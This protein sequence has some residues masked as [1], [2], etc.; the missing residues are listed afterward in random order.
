MQ[1]RGPN[2]PHFAASAISTKSVAEK[3]TSGTSL[4]SRLRNINIKVLAWTIGVLALLSMIATSMLLISNYIA[5]SELR[6][7]L[8]KENLTAP[9]SFEDERAVAKVLATLYLV[10]DIRYAEIYGANGISQG[11][12]VRHALQAG[13]EKVPLRLEGR[14]IE[15]TR[16][17]FFSTVR[18][19]GARLG[20]L[21]L[22]MDLAPY[23][24]QLL[25][26]LLA[27]LLV[28]PLAIFLAM[29]KQSQ[30]VASVTGPLFDLARRIDQVSDG[31]LDSGT[32]IAPSAVKEID[33]LSHGF[34]QMVA[35]IRKRDQ[36]LADQVDTLEA[37]VEHR[38]AELRL[39]KDA[40]EAGSRAK[41]E[42][43][44]TMSHEIRTPMNGVLGMTELLLQTPL[45]TNQQHYVEAVE[46]SGRHLLGIIN[47]ILDFSKIESGCVALEAIEVNLFELIE[48]TATMFA[49]QIQ[50]KGLELA[51]AL[52]AGPAVMV[53]TDPMRLRQIL[54]NLL[55]NAAKFT[56]TGEITIYLTIRNRSA[57]KIALDLTVADTGIGIAPA[58]H[59]LIFEHFSQA[60]GSTARKFGGTGLGLTISRMLARMLGG[61]ITVESATGSGARFHVALNL[62]TCDLLTHAG[63]DSLALTGQQV[64]VV[65]DNRTNCTILATQL[66]RWGITPHV[67][68]SGT[69]AM[70]MLNTASNQGLSISLA[71]VDVSMAGMDGHVLAQCIRAEP[72][73]EH[74]QLVMLL[75]ACDPA[76]APSHSQLKIG[77]S[78]NK[79]VRQMA[80]RHAISQNAPG[81]GMLL[82]QPTLPAAV[83]VA[84]LKW[85]GKVLL[86]EDTDVNQK[87]AM[88]WLIK[89]GVEVTLARNGHEALA[90]TREDSFDL[91]LMD[92]QMPEMDGFEATR[93]IRQDELHNQSVRTP[94]VALTANAM[95]GD[96]EKCL[97]AGMDDYLAKPYS[98]KQLSV[99]LARWLE[100]GTNQTQ[101]PA[102]VAKT[103]IDPAGEAG[104]GGA[105]R[106]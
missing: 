25:Q 75:S 33:R 92:C 60:D 29:R 90:L 81:D 91:I 47:D 2:L 64:L 79:P 38:T 76:P 93:Q 10:P 52:P 3:I 5:D 39:A 30:L 37:Q 17:L 8:L 28:I 58:A 97:H 84:T 66:R 85:R 69:E 87:L 7:D 15:A 80:L 74:M 14:T 71:L 67:A 88:A 106:E 55:A 104:Q 21:V 51:V 62:P 6:L 42:F 26:V 63:D 95:G 9:M 19:D 41:S 50:A 61:D 46:Q 70:A 12:Y 34:M 27:T 57:G 36:Q 40:A 4:S 100:A 16:V 98:G 1:I 48:E 59:A 20:T 86:A 24:R 73:F 32:A 68:H 23:Y 82:L 49:H 89:L 18:L 102:V 11:R 56:V 83:A 72:R 99:V 45:D 103:I 53:R 96:R 13:R 101:L 54:V 94:I 78:I 31:Q 22:S 43:L 44:A 35:E 77:A 65:D 105:D